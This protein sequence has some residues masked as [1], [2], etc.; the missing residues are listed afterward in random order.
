MNLNAM[1]VQA[2][3]NFPFKAA[4]CSRLAL[5]HCVGTLSDMFHL[6]LLGFVLNFKPFAQIVEFMTRCSK[7][8]ALID[9]YAATAEIV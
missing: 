4:V 8:L 1:Y 3:R 5:V 7:I 6:Q 2:A 9:C